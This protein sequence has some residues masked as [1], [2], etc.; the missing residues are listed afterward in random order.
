MF[1]H[2]SLHACFKAEQQHG[3]AVTGATNISYG[4]KASH[5]KVR[6]Y[7]RSYLHVLVA[8]VDERYLLDDALPHSALKHELKALHHGLRAKR[9]SSRVS[10]LSL[11][12]L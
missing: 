4:L 10:F 8:R 1:G 2:D 7:G 12:T 9:G 5:P 6:R 11:A 3:L